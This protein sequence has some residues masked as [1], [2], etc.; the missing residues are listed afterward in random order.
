MPA[1]VDQETRSLRTQF[2]TRGLTQKQQREKRLIWTNL[3][4]T[5]GV[6]RRRQERDESQQ[7]E[8]P[9]QPL[10]GDSLPRQSPM[11]TRPQSLLDLEEGGGECC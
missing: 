7:E 10:K 5:N 9:E 3:R 1:L 11:P 2:S 6:N 8:E 4:W